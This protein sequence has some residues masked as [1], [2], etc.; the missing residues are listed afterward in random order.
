MDYC[1]ILIGEELLKIGLKTMLAQWVVSTVD[2][3]TTRERK[4]VGGQQVVSP[5][6]RSVVNFGIS[7]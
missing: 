4:M 2:R 6:D 1:C 3:P 7:T 5:I